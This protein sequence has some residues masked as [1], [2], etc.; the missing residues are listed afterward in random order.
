M[1]NHSIFSILLID[2]VK[3]SV[4]RFRFPTTTLVQPLCARRQRDILWV[5]L[6]SITSCTG[7]QSDGH[8]LSANR[9]L[10]VDHIYSPAGLM[11]RLPISIRFHSASINRCTFL[12]CRLFISLQVVFSRLF[13]WLQVDISMSSHLFFRPSH[14]PVS[15]CAALQMR[16]ILFAFLFVYVH[17]HFITCLSLR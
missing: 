7:S 14:L 10:S 13:D 6:E 11:Q 1:F 15:V 5:S 12:P 3:N 16:F 2:L 4:G 17:S 8:C 9:C